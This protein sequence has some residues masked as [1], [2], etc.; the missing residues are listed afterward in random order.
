MQ[1]DSPT[2]DTLASKEQQQSWEAAAFR[3]LLDHL[4]S[5]RDVQN[6][7]IMELGGFCRNCLARWYAE[8]AA[9]DGV[10]ISTATARER[11]YGMP[12]SE[13]KSKWQK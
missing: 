12:Y 6:L 8:A 3:H 11:V 4:D 2:I 1:H 13:W 10:T 5:R 7:S 9:A